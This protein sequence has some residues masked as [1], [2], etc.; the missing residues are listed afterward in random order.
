MRAVLRHRELMARGTNGGLAVRPRQSC[1]D[2]GAD[3][4]ARR[5]PPLLNRAEVLAP[6]AGAPRDSGLDR[7]QGACVLE[8]AMMPRCCGGAVSWALAARCSSAGATL[9]RSGP[10]VYGTF[11]KC[12]RPGNRIVAILATVKPLHGCRPGN[13]RPLIVAAPATVLLPP[14]QPCFVFREPAAELP[15]AKVK[16]RFRAVAPE[17]GERPDGGDANL[18]GEAA[19]LMAPDETLVLQLGECRGSLVQPGLEP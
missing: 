15:C 10:I 19:T 17:H 5:P 14:R 12:C 1:P 18:A 8:P 16:R 7:D 11:Y 4:R 3:V 6:D 2:A 9:R 13:N